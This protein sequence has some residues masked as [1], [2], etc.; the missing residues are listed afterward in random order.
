MII[1]ADNQARR[2]LGSVRR[3]LR[4]ITL[5]GLLTAQQKVFAVA[6]ETKNVSK[7]S[8]AP[9][10]RC[11]LK[12]SLLLAAARQPSNLAPTARQTLIVSSLDTSPS[13]T[14]THTRR[15]S[16]ATIFPPLPPITTSSL[17][18]VLP[19]EFHPQDARRATK[20]GYI[21]LHG[22]QAVS[23]RVTHPGISFGYHS[24]QRETY[25]ETGIRQVQ[26]SQTGNIHL[27]ALVHSVDR[28]R[29]WCLLRSPWCVCVIPFMSP[30]Y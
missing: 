26:Y 2:C 21:R 8:E 28:V 4:L 29:S 24:T 23:Y 3:E 18:N 6:W 9:P 16:F 19:A 11:Y 30:K 12:V 22:Y 13:S 25:T 1:A 17:S 15:C 14:G 7:S 27:L 20:G 10:T 5:P